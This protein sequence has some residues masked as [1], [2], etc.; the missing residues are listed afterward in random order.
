VSP[1]GNPGR[2]RAAPISPMRLCDALRI[3]AFRAAE[4]AIPD[5]TKF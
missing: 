3:G 4:G 2:P 1:Q 5:M